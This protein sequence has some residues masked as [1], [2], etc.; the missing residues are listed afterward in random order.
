WRMV[1]FDLVHGVISS[2]RESASSVIARRNDE[3][4][5]SEST[6]LA[7]EGIAALRAQGAPR[8][9]AL[10]MTTW[11]SSSRVPPAVPKSSILDTFPSCGRVEPQGGSGAAPE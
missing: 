5:P 4:I 6:Y 7:P 1:G 9:P 3:A 10:A 8:L 11:L 2:I